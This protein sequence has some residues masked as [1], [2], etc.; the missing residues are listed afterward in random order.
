MLIEGRSWTTLC[1]TN[2]S[3]RLLREKKSFTLFQF[4]L[5][6]PTETKS[7]FYI[8]F[9]EI[10]FFMLIM[11]DIIYVD[12]IWHNC[13]LLGLHSVRGSWLYIDESVFTFWWTGIQWGGG[14][15]LELFDVVLPK[16]VTRIQFLIFFFNTYFFPFCWMFFFMWIRKFIWWIWLTTYLRHWFL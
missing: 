15:Y 10:L 8:E 6:L 14:L 1:I 16:K 5:T 4:R 11:F 12:N 3:T 13:L 2:S 9:L 7:L